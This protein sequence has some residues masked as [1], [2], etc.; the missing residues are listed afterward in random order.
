MKKKLPQ[1]FRI[2]LEKLKR[3]KKILKSI[4]R[5]NNFNTIE[6]LK[7]LKLII[8]KSKMLLML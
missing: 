3:K 2:I 7:S 8:R 4:S 5:K 1:K 6:L